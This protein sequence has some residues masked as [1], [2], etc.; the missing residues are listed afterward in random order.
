MILY[1][2]KW[3]HR[4]GTL[5]HLH[6]TPFDGDTSKRR[7]TDE[8]AMVHRLSNG[9][10]ASVNGAGWSCHKSPTAAKRWTERALD[11]LSIRLFDVDTLTFEDSP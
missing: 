7:L 3:K 10:H 2:H 9:W 11:R 1:W 4:R 5:Y 8:V 6:P